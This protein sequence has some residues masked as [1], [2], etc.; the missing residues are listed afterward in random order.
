MDFRV[1]ASPPIHQAAIKN[2]MSDVSLHSIEDAK[3]YACKMTNRSLTQDV[4]Q[5]RLEYW[6]G[7]LDKAENWHNLD[8]TEIEQSKNVFRGQIESIKDWLESEEFENGDFPQ[9]IDELMLELIEWRALK[10]AFQ[11]TETEKSPFKDHI[12]F[13]QWLIGGTYAV[14]SILG[15][16]VSKDKRDNSLKNL[17]QKLSPFIEQDGACTN[18]EIEY[19]NRKLHDTSGHFKKENSKTISF[20]NTVI[21]HN[22]KNLTIK[23]GEIDKDIEILVR[24]WSLIV[25]WSS[26][27]LFDPFRTSEQAFSGLESFF[28]GQELTLLKAKRTEYLD[29]VTRWSVTHLHNGVRDTG[30]GSFSKLV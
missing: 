23:W 22:E 3:N 26:F 21:A 24:I 8:N 27:G 13:S 10:Y 25:S 29:R 9:G 11:N 19:I 15:K 17:W 6:K 4:A 18:E 12:F 16:L 7:Q 28:A 14:F 2:K 30:R 20:R 1:V 5:R